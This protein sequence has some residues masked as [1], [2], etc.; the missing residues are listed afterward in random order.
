MNAAV[1][2]EFMTVL[3]NMPNEKIDILLRFA[4]WS[5]KTIEGEGITKG[6]MQ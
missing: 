2:K 6:E 4:S 3:E 1:K 5:R